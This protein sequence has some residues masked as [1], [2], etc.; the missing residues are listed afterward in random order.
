MKT[1]FK[2][3]CAPLLGFSM[4]T[5]MEDPEGN[6]SAFIEDRYET[7]DMPTKDEVFEEMQTT[8][9]QKQKPLKESMR[10]R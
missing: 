6:L 2:I 1:I 5:C 3:L 9:M 7:K 4:L 10:N 8:S